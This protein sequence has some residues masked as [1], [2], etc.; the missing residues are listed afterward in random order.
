MEP[1]GEKLREAREA[2]GLSI[3]QLAAATKIRRDYLLALEQ[4]DRASLPGD[5]Y[6][7]GFLRLYAREVGLDP[8][9]VASE[10]REAR[11]HFPGEPDASRWKPLTFPEGE[12]AVYRRLPEGPPR[13]SAGRSGRRG[14]GRTGRR[15]VRGVA[16][17]I[18]L[19]VV[20]VG[21]SLRLFGPEVGLARLVG[22]GTG[23]TARLRE[24]SAGLQALFSM[25]A[26]LTLRETPSRDGEGGASAA[27]GSD[28]SPASG[29]GDVLPGG[30]MGGNGVPLPPP[31]WD[32]W[33][34]LSPAPLAAAPE[35]DAAE[36]AEE[37]AGEPEAGGGPR[38]Q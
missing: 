28:P 6:V 38:A 22:D 5:V 2:R 33:W 37:E 34:E 4:G 21:V 24:R 26:E 36:G 16:A 29:A 17:L 31:N 7:K 8:D 32:V 20:A 35:G 13:R 10:Y 12:P 19:L 3:D 15:S 11:R 1:L 27:R 14:T 25:E 9:E 23:L 30:V 18:L